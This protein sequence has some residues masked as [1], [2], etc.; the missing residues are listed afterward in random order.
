MVVHFSDVT[1]G[2]NPIVITRTYRAYDACSNY[3]QCEQTI[4]ATPDTTPPGINIGQN[5]TVSCYQ[6]WDFTV[7]IITN[8]CGGYTLTALP[9]RSDAR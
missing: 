7:P 4:T 6:G 8:D 3:A 9:H 1:N 5:E 2:V